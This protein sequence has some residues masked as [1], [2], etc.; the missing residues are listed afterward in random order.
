MSL[1]LFQSFRRYLNDAKAVYISEYYLACRFV[2]MTLRL[3]LKFRV[4]SLNINSHQG[5]DSQISQ[6]PLKEKRDKGWNLPNPFVWSV[7]PVE[8]TSLCGSSRGYVGGDTR[9]W[10]AAYD[11]IK[12]S[13][14]FRRCLLVSRLILRILSIFVWFGREY[15]RRKLN[16]FLMAP[17]RESVNFFLFTQHWNGGFI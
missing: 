10:T 7:T 11:C 1:C 14:Q 6:R 16:M 17:V 5:S 4:T 12:S 13:R 3:H 15:V 9:R 8:W 2:I